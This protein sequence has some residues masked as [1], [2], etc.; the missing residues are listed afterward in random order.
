MYSS[1]SLYTHWKLDSGGT[2]T[3]DLLLSSAPF[4][5]FFHIELNVAEKS[6]SLLA[7]YI[8]FLFHRCKNICQMSSKHSG[9]P[10]NSRPSWVIDSKISVLQGVFDWPNRK[11]IFFISQSSTTSLSHCR[12]S[13]D[14]IRLDNRSCG[15]LHWFLLPTIKVRDFRK[16][17]TLKKINGETSRNESWFVRKPNSERVHMLLNFAR[18]FA[19]QPG[20]PKE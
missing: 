6:Y 17:L 7:S 20:A 11:R 4:S 14:G 19:K 12:I 13:P 9:A 2:S 18:N 16:S 10:K 15:W 5:Q 8:L 1:E 3:H